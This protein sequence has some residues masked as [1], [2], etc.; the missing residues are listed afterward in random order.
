MLSHDVRDLLKAEQE[1]HPLAALALDLFCYR[2]RKYIGA[3][4]AVL[5]GSN[6]VVF[7]GGIG[8]HAPAIR[9]RIC[10]GMAWCGLMLDPE[11]NASAGNPQPG[12]VM[13]VSADSA[14]LPVYVVGV[15]EEAAIARETVACLRSIRA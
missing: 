13:K 5:G 2:V 7:G 6:A 10:A 4:L 11:R 9:A 14:S 3:Y 12:Q 15:D 1:G 8:E